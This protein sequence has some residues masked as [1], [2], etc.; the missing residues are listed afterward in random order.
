MIR[1]SSYTIYKETIV[2]ALSIP[3]DNLKVRLFGIPRMKYRN[4]RELAKNVLKRNLIDRNVVLAGWGHFRLMWVADT[5]VAFAGLKQV[6]PKQA[7]RRIIQHIIDASDRRGYVTAGFSNKR[8]IDIPYHRG[9]SL[10]WLLYMC[11]RYMDWYHD[12]A[13]LKR[14]K[15]KIQKLIKS[16]EQQTIGAD[17]LVHEHI[18]GDWADTLKRPSS[19]WN[20]IMEL[21]VLRFADKYAFALTKIPKDLEKRIISKRLK[22]T[23]LVDHAGSDLPSIDGMILALYLGI[24]GPAVRRKLAVFL[25]THADRFPSVPTVKDFPKKLVTKLSRIIAPGYHTQASWIHLGLMM[26]NGYKRLGRN[27]KDRLTVIES[28]VEK[29]G[30]F[31]EIVNDKG[32]I[33]RK[34]ITSEYGFTMSAGQYLEAVKKK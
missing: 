7:L 16:Y 34:G 15:R 27:Y 21:F 25:E 1:I 11:D 30:N 17:G 18:R 23:F 4:L 10:P 20:N 3:I 9:D 13:F 26:V 6:L 2:T 24:F 29:Y 33:F 5:A 12:K 8:A 31:I 28:V 22:G 32:E 14:N 19:T